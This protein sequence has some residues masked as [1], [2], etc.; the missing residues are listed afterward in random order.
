M[1]IDIRTFLFHYS[2]LSMRIFEKMQTSLVRIT[3]AAMDF[4]I[5]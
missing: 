1:E 5:K 3:Y 4:V 2:G